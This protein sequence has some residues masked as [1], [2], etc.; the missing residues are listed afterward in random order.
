M[1]HH[2]CTVLGTRPQFVKATMISKALH[3][4]GLQ[5]SIVHTGQHY[6]TALDRSFFEELQMPQPV[7]NLGVGSGHHSWQIGTMMIR[8]EEWLLSQKILPDAVLVYGDTNSTLSGALVAAKLRLPIIHI[9]AGLRS[10]NRNMPEETNRILTDTLA[11]WCFCPTETAVQH[12]K[13]EGKQS[14]VFLCG[15]VMHDA[16]VFFGEQ[17]KGHVPPAF[18]ALKPQGY[19]VL[20]IHRAENTDDPAQFE[21]ILQA[22]AH[23]DQRVVWPVHPRTRHFLTAHTLPPNLHPLSPLGYLDMMALVRNAKVVLTDSGGLQ[24]EAYWL[25]VPCITL[26]NETEWP[27]TLS[28]GWNKLSGNRLKDL[29]EMVQTPPKGSRP[30]FGTTG[31]VGAS[32]LIVQTLLDELSHA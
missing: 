3:K 18:S 30:H 4:A 19:A 28:N 22:I 2:I 13:N 7:V 17:V 15:D 23:I 26:R 27:E 29:P 16:T 25:G 12:L 24:K 1:S 31:G 21:A 5:E 20:T 32:T 10:F 8:L 9:E 11:T 6:D 14:G